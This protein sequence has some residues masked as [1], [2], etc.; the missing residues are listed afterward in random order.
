MRRPEFHC[1]GP[2][3]LDRIIRVDR[4]PGPDDKAFVSSKQDSA[5]GPARNVAF[6]LAGW[7][8]RVTAAS[9]VGD[10]GVGQRLLE[11]LSEAGVGTD[12]IERVPDLET[13]SCTII[14]DKSGE[15]AILIEPID[16]VVL[17]RIG[18]GLR[19]A[20]GDAVLM[21]LFHD[22]AAFDLLAGARSAG[23]LAFIDLEWPEI[24][25][26][27]WAAAKRAAAVA[28]VVVTNR[29]VLKA[30]AEE[31]GMV[32]DDAAAAV[33]AQ[34]LRPAGDRVCVTLGADGVLA[35]DG[36]RLLRVSAMPVTPQNTTGA[37]DRFL[38]GLARALTAGIPFDRSLA[39]GVAAA[40]LYLSG[41]GENWA[42]VER[43]SATVNVRNLLA[44]VLS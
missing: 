5:G 20:A 39:H 4:I 41:S 32:V 21:N 43:A 44:G 1:V 34:E 9:V 3:V 10:D 18:S 23:A 8:E 17:A 42:D 25:R 11:R 22:H 13:A 33:L 27:G 26:W 28:D 40:G 38:A 24:G 37:G 29:Q 16:E 12:A 30:F 35:R 36:N 2:V 6:A 15:R 19:P 14:L 31:R 7:G